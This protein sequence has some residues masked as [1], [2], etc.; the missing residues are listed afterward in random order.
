[1]PDIQIIIGFVGFFIQLLAVL[2]GSLRWKKR[3]SIQRIVIVMLSIS[4]LIQLIAREVGQATGN[5]L[6]MYHMTMLIETGFIW[7]IY[8]FQL[9]SIL[10]QKFFVSIAIFYACFFIYSMLYL[11][12]L[13]EFPAY[14]RFVESIIVIFF[15][16]TYYVLC[17]RQLDTQLIHR[18]FMF[19]VSTGLLLYFTSNLLITLFGN[20]LIQ[21]SDNESWQAIWSVH[22][23]LNVILYICF[24]IAFLQKEGRS[25][26][27]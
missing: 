12:S 14:I 20:I 26:K 7:V 10:S 17:L 8:R 3:T 16:I 23:I 15:C 1:M 19:W 6:W 25:S 5:S 4:W 27:T 11:Q 18:S 13:S 22:N 9:R 2:I 21:E 24:I